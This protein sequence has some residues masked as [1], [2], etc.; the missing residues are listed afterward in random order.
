MNTLDILSSSSLRGLISESEIEEL[1][2]ELNEE[3]ESKFDIEKEAIKDS[4]QEILEDTRKKNSELEKKIETLENLFPA[5]KTLESVMTMEW[6]T[7]NWEDVKN[8]YRMNMPVK[9][10]LEL[11]RSC[12]VHA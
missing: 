1:S 11:L 7:E 5:E 8:L 12:Q 4:F 2:E 9:Q 10:V 3:I 6:I